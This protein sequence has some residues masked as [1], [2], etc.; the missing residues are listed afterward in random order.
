MKLVRAYFCV[1]R[2]NG[3]KSANGNGKSISINRFTEHV[4]N[5]LKAQLSNKV[6]NKKNEQAAAWS[7]SL[8][9]C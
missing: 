1:D 5:Y 8:A 3:Q 2:L 9:A 4:L 6:C 7:F